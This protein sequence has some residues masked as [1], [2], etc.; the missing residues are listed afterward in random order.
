MADFTRQRRREFALRVALGATRRSVIGLVLAAG[1]RLAAIGA[2]AGVL[3][4][5]VIARWLAHVMPTVGSLTVWVWLA[6]PLV[7]ATAVLFAGVIPARR[8]LMVDPLT[9][10]RDN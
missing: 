5:A 8:A 10:M 3:A 6:G 4:A 7:L 9:I 1:A 2:V